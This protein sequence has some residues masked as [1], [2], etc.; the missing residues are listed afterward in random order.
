MLQSEAKAHKAAEHLDHMYKLSH[1]PRLALH[2]QHAINEESFLDADL[3]RV[4]MPHYDA[5]VITLQVQNIE[6]DRILVDLGEGANI[7]FLS[8]LLHM[9]LTTKDVKKTQSFSSWI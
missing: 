7:I 9:E 1:K 3:K 5:L 8:T 4:D 6:V 2:K